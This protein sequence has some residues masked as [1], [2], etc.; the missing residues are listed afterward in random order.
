MGQKWTLWGGC[1]VLSFDRGLGY[2]DCMHVWNS[3]DSPLKICTCKFYLRKE[4]QNW[5]L[6]NN[7]H[8]KVFREK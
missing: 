6:V 3:S 2:T 8:A 5:T 1:N 7:I 4:Q